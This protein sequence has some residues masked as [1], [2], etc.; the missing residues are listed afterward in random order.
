MARIV[1]GPIDEFPAGSRKVIETR[2]GMS[3]GVFNVDGTLYAVLNRCP[4]QGAPLCRG[5]VSASIEASTPGSYHYGSRGPLLRCPWHGWE[6]DLA[7]G[8]SWCDPDTSRV[9]VYDV[10]IES[11]PV[12]VDGGLV[13]IDTSHR[14]REKH[15][16]DST[17]DA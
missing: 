8:R 16:S 12:S 13:V 11:F 5:S 14:R 15:S 6:F 10:T 2:S 1:A 4:H 7:S 9:R 17:S 3:I